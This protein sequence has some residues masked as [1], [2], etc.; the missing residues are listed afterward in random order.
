MDGQRMKCEMAFDLEW[1]ATR[2]FPIACFVTL[3]PIRTGSTDY[4]LL[5]DRSSRIRCTPQLLKPLNQ[6][7]N[8]EIFSSAAFH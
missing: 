4:N 7:S 8:L 3:S 5:K 1:R 6:D 2:L